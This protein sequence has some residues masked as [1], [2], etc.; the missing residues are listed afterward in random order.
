MKNLIDV[1]KGNSFDALQDTV[2][3]MIYNG[4]PLVNILSQLLDEIVVDTGISD[5]NKALICEKLAEVD[6]ALSDGAS[7]LLQLMDVCAF[8]MRRLTSYTA[9]VDSMTTSNH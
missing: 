3:E 5:L 8:I 1:M 4:F 6:Q 7:E 2:S 9:D